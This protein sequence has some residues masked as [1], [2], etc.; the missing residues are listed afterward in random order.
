MN[1]KSPSSPPPLPV[2]SQDRQRLTRL[3]VPDG[4]QIVRM[5]IVAQDLPDRALGHAIA[6]RPIL[7]DQRVQARAHRLI[8]RES[9][10]IMRIVLPIPAQTPER[11]P[12]G[13]LRRLEG[14]KLY[15]KRV[16]VEVGRMPLI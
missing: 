10:M 7:N 3:A 16:N 12:D 4:A 6:R 14:G 2:G 15:V 8:L 5:A 11:A 1:C 9:N 13:I